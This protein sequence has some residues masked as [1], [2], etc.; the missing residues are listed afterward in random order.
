VTSPPSRGLKETATT[1]CIAL[2][3]HA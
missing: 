3:A 2:H 1:A